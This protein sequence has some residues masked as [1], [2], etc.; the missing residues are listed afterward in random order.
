MAKRRT[1][2]NIVTEIPKTY[3]K[4]EKGKEIFDENNQL[5]P[6]DYWRYSDF[7]MLVMNQKVPEGVT[8]QQMKDDIAIV[9]AI[10]DHDDK[11]QLK[12]SEVTRLRNKLESFK[13]GF[14]H[15]ELLKFAAAIEKL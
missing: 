13:W 9:D 4:D 7:I 15:K 6:V 11:I 5:I 8:I 10:E 14:A 3:E 12:D 1:L 2:E